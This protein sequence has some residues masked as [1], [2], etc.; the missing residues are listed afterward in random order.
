MCIVPDTD[1]PEDPKL[2][3]EY[4]A[5]RNPDGEAVR[6]TTSRRT[7]DRMRAGTDTILTSP[8]GVTTS[9]PTAGKTL[10]GQ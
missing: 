9:A 4:A 3:P 5:Q 8:S 2:P 10:L 6:S 1:K 7:G